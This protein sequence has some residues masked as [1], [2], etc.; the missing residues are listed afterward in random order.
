MNCKNCGS[1]L[2]EGAKFCTKCGQ[3]VAE[4]VQEAVQETV[5]EVT[6]AAQE[7]VAEA[8]EAVQEAATEAAE[9]AQE[10]VA[11]ATEAAQETVAEATEA[12]QDSVAEAAEAVQEAATEV[13]EAAQETVVEATE[14]AQEKVSLA[15]ETAQEAVAEAKE[16]A[17]EKVTL[18]K[19]TTQEKAADTKATVKEEAKKDAKE[20]DA[21]QGAAKKLLKNPVLWV[22]VV[23]VLAILVIFNFKVVSNTAMKLFSSPAKYYAHVEK[24][25]I[26]ELA[27]DLA[28]AYDNM[29]LSNASVYDTSLDYDISL[30]LSETAYEML[31]D[32]AGFD[33]ASGL[34]KMAIETF[35]SV[36]GDSISAN[37]AATVGKSDLISV[38]FVADLAE[39]EAYVQIPELNEKYIG[40]DISDYA[41]EIAD[42]LK[43]SEE[44]LAL[45]PKK[46]TVESILNRYME[47]VVESIDEDA[48]SKKSDEISVGDIEQKCTCLTI[49][50]KEK[51]LVQ[52]TEAILTEAKNDKELL[53]V[54][55]AFGEFTYGMDE[56]EIREYYED[57]IDSALEDLEDAKEK[58]S[59][60]EL[61]MK[62]WVNNKGEV[63][64]REIEIDDGEVA[65]L[66]QM[67][68]KGKN[69]EYEL[70]LTEDGED[71]F[72]LTG[73]GTKNGSSLSG[74]FEVEI[75]EYDT[76]LSMAEI[77]VEKLNIEK[78]KQGL[79]NGTFT[80]KPTSS[81]YYE[82][83]MGS[84]YSVVSDYAIECE[85]SSAK[86]EAELSI[87]LVDAEE[88]FA[89]LT[90]S[91]KRGSGKSVSLPKKGI[92]VEEGD[93][94]ALQEWVDGIDLDKFLKK[95]K[96]SALPEELIEMI[97]ELCEDLEDELD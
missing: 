75:V 85:M 68:M 15:K 26:K 47:I 52:V 65:I 19:E 69:F 94:D 10:T 79:I 80:I 57:S 34:S 21:T 18:A 11:E 56:D 20:K 78:A 3:R 23:A 59:E 53:D 13:T 61:K 32:V 36:K 86:S 83:G 35:F 87:A 96:K 48:V 88:K 51:D 93:E 97:E 2:E 8:T 43:Q 50:M 55:I 89:T 84:A 90:V 38:N 6:E 72:A 12:A 49:K 45:Y 14:A 64:G 37:A 76:K 1:L 7:T 54:L 44:M 25:E 46:K 95:I 73:A 70:V 24:G 42:A 60:A 62:V 71:I 22:A 16:A 17:Q 77:S 9:A 74:D 63:V 33:D 92:L 81:L 66:Y 30:E 67:P 39:A 91:A 5:A 31:G 29:F 40:A 82:M 27:S 41:E 58:E 4:E 28:L